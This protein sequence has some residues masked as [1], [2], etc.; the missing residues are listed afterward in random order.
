MQQA[1]NERVYSTE[2]NERITKVYDA[3]YESK[4][5]FFK[6]LT[7]KK[8]LDVGCGT[9]RLAAFLNTQ[10][11]ECWGITISHA[12][13][14]N[15]RE[16]M[17]AVSVADAETCADLP[18]DDQFFDCIVF[19]DILEHFKQPELVLKK[20]LRY[21]KP[22]GEVVISLPNV[23]NFKVRTEIFLGKF[24]YTPYGILDE[25]HLRF[26]TLKTARDMIEAQTLLIDEVRYTFW[27]WKIPVLYRIG[28]GSAAWTLQSLLTRLFPGF[29][30]TQFVFKCRLRGAAV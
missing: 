16:H 3:D 5:R 11:N 13:A 7:D 24:N 20:M 18:F 15:A 21:L 1:V 8:I 22:A 12:E 28:K 29:F 10:G 30:A 26:F 14:E 25:T 23:V 19:A 27:N 17:K 9:G 2:A 6:H 4:K